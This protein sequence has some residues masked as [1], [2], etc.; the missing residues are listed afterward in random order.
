M[1]R[2]RVDVVASAVEPTISLETDGKGNGNWQIGGRREKPA[3]R[4]FHRQ[5]CLRRSAINNGTMT[6][7]MAPPAR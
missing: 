1:L 2:R 7:T 5:A 4:R 3:G 6:I